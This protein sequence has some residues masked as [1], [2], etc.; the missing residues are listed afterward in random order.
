M[1]LV[2]FE[3][4]ARAAIKRGVSL[5]AR[6][7]RTTLGPCGRSVII[8]QSF[9]SPIITKDGVTVARGDRT[10]GPVRKRRFENG[11]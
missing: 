5:L 8:E 2:A 6:T 3:S 1:K 7:V 11:S 9:G 4:D 10:I